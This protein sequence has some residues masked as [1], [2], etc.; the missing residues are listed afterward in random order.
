ML[1]FFVVMVGLLGTLLLSVGGLV[2]LVV[3]LA[4]GRPGPARVPAGIL[5]GYFAGALF[6]WS[7]VPRDWELPLWTTVAATVD[8]EKYGHAVEHAA[9]GIVVW[10]LFA[11]VVGAVIGGFAAIWPW[12]PS[13]CP[14]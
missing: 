6:V 9:E 5:C 4:H 11:G 10:M 2:Y 1:V 8:A 3:T 7:L 14:R 13:P 12:R